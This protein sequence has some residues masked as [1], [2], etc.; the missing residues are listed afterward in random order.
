[1]DG[2]LPEQSTK[3]LEVITEK[4]CEN[5]LVKSLLEFSVDTSHLDL[6]RCD[7]DMNSSGEWDEY[8][9]GHSGVGRNM[10]KV[11]SAPRLKCVDHPFRSLIPADRQRYIDLLSSAKSYERDERFEEAAEHYLGALKLCDEDVLLHKKLF[12]LQQIL[13][14]DFD[15]G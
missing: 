7:D 4:K 5:L 15:Q 3:R 2:T 10:K 8:D 11:E 14:S 1:M 12:I 6:P 9:S 13:C